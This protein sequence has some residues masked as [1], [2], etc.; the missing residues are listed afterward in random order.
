MKARLLKSIAAL[1]AYSSLILVFDNCSQIR[2]LMHSF[3]PDSNQAAGE[4]PHPP[5]TNPT[6]PPT[7]K[8]LLVHRTYVTELMRD[9]FTSTNHPVALR[10]IYL[11]RLR[12]R[13]LE[14]K[15]LFVSR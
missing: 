15:S 4:I 9:I 6:V 5:V 14:F 1:V 2:M 11:Q 7:Q 3:N 10:H 8:T 12:R 13:H